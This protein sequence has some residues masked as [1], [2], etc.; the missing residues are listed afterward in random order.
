MAIEVTEQDIE[1]LRSQAQEQGEQMYHATEFGAQYHLSKQFGEGC[2]RVIQLRGGL[3]IFI[4]NNQ[5]WQRLIIKKQHEDTFPVT[6]KFYLSGSSRIK[7]KN[8]PEIAA[9]YEEV[10]G[11]NYLYHL[12]Y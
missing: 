10:A 9:D 2:D 12:S 1:D 4:R 11:C 7:T 3:T 6:A 8:V 5:F